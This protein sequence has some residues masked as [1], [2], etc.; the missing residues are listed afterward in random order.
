MPKLRSR[1]L[2]P[3]DERTLYGDIL[4]VLMDYA[5]RFPQADIGELPQIPA[6]GEPSSGDS[7]GDARPDDGAA[8]SRSSRP[9]V[10]LALAA[11][12]VSG[13]VIGAFAEE[14]RYDSRPWLIWASLL[15]CA[16]AWLSFVATMV[17]TPTPADR[18]HKRRKDQDQG[19]VAM[20]LSTALGVVTVELATDFSAANPDGRLVHELLVI[21]G[22][23]VPPMIVRWL[24]RRRKSVGWLAALLGAVAGLDSIL[25]SNVSGTVCVV[26][27]GTT[28]VL[29]PLVVHQSLSGIAVRDLAGRWYVD[30][31]RVLNDPGWI[32]NSEWQSEIWDVARPRCSSSLCTISINSSDGPFVLT[33]RTHSLLFEGTRTTTPDCSAEG[34]NGTATTTVSNGYR[35]EEHLSVYLRLMANRAD[36]SLSIVDRVSA[37]AS[38]AAMADHC[39]RHTTAQL[40]TTATS[41][42]GPATGVG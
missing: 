38:E 10:V 2:H 6:S 7:H 33:G 3:R 9:A 11:T 24:L 28:C 26:A 36:V 32:K 17:R 35:A 1:H 18:P 20:A 42:V 14:P 39:L 31:Y 19:Y 34:P 25:R 40:T 12:L 21:I 4:R 37:W 30:Q 13:I 27:A 22:A 16:L 41:L 23:A 5:E 29:V 15:G 8:K